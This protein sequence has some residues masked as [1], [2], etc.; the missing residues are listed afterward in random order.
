MSNAIRIDDLREPR[1]SP[2]QQ[3]V[4]DATAGLQV[5]LSVDEV[6]CA[7]RE[8]TGLADFGPEDFLERLGLLV[9]E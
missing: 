5:E 3:A 9:D 2:A 4:I 7:A 8:R 1:L 6:L